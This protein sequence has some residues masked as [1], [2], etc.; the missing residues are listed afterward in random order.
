MLPN[1]KAVSQ[2]PLQWSQK[3]LKEMDAC[4]L[5]QLQDSIWERD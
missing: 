5:Q 3:L 4:R 1:I 2:I